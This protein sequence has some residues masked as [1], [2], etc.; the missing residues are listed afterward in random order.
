MSWTN[1]E[2]A[3]AAG[4]F[5]GEG[6]LTV[7][8]RSGQRYLEPLVS[9]SNTD[10]RMVLW[11]HERFGGSLGYKARNGA[12][13]ERAKPLHRWSLD[14]YDAIGRCIGAVRPFLITKA[15]QAD[16]LLALVKLKKGR[17]QRY[18]PDDISRRVAIK[19]QMAILNKRG[20]A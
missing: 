13:A 9:V 15:D 6:T 14:G 4:I 7:R 3:Y 1:E 10:P 11:L 12:R 5:D 17:G 16:L 8:G 2:L 18:D 20:A 19:N